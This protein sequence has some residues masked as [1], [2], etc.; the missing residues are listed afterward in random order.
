[1]PKAISTRE[2]ADAMNGPD[3]LQV[4]DVR[5]LPAFDASTRMIASA[6]WRNPEDIEN[7]IFALASS[8]D[9]VVYCV[10]GHQVSQGCADRLAKAG[11]RAAYLAGG[12]EQWAAENRLTVGKPSRS[13]S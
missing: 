12:L 2:L 11:F 1:M 4:I 6:S 9:V 5:R 3:E 10:H 8:Q 13:P 7:W